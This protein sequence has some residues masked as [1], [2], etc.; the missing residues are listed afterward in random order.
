MNNTYEHT[1]NKVEKHI[2][3]EK[4]EKEEEVGRKET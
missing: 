4:D 2:V 3:R 1:V